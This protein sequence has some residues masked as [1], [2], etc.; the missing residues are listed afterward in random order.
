MSSC[1]AAA[2][3]VPWQYSVIARSEAQ[4]T[5]KRR[6]LRC[7]GTALSFSSGFAHCKRC[8]S[9]TMASPSRQKL[10]AGLGQTGQKLASTGQSYLPSWL[11]VSHVV[12][13]QPEEILYNQS[14][15]A[16]L[17]CRHLAIEPCTIGHLEMCSRS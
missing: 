11:A 13:K 9:A 7:C 5:I 17:V 15:V 8:E 2:P 14:T 12:L 6:G 1:T 16:Y 4:A 3:V 10:Q